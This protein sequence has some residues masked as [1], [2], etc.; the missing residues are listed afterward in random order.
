MALHPHFSSGTSTSESCAM[1]L[2][3][4]AMNPS[5]EVR[6]SNVLP[7]FL[8]MVERMRMN[9][10]LLNNA[11]IAIFIAN[12]QRVR[13][14]DMSSVTH[15]CN[16]AADILRYYACVFASPVGSKQKYARGICCCCS[17]GGVLCTDLRLHLYMDTRERQ[18]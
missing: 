10:S 5:E 15:S 3:C 16:A 12:A 18:L 11:C 6:D 8:Y 2:E 1:T 17:G 4:Y 9:H 7:S 14:T 13:P